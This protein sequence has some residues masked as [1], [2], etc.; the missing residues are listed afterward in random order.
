MNPVNLPGEAAGTDKQNEERLND[1]MLTLKE[2]LMITGMAKEADIQGLDDV[3]IDSLEKKI[4]PGEKF[5]TAYRSFLRIFGR[6][7]GWFFQGTDIF[8]PDILENKQAFLATFPD[9]DKQF[10]KRKVCKQKC[11]VFAMHQGY[12]FWYFD[13][14]QITHDGNPPVSCIQDDGNVLVDYNSSFTEFLVKE[15]EHQ[16]AALQSCEELP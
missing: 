13:L 12:L 1:V 7:A 9:G 5:A 3:L 10:P 15:F 8:Y 4:I 16:L 2:S 14:R 6:G 11:H